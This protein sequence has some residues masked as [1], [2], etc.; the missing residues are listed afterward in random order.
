MR[1]R[2]SVAYW[3]SIHWTTAD[4]LGTTQNS[5]F[6]GEYK[7]GMATELPL[8]RR[9]QLAALAHIRHTH[10]RYDKLLRETTWA[11]ARKAVEQACLDVI[12]KWRGDEETG[13]DQLDEILRE[14]IEIS[15]DEGGSD[16]DSSDAE[17]APTTGLSRGKSAGPGTGP[18][19]PTLVR[20]PVPDASV[21]AA[22]TPCQLKRQTRKERKKARIE[23]KKA[24][25]RYRRYAALAD[26]PSNGSDGPGQAQNAPNAANAAVD[27]A[28]PDS[29]PPSKEQ[30]QTPLQAQRLEQEEYRRHFPSGVVVYPDSGFAEPRNNSGPM[31]ARHVDAPAR[32]QSPLFV[33]VRDGNAPKV[34]LAPPHANGQMPLSPVR[35][36]LEDML[37][38]SIEP[39][40]P[41]GYRSPSNLGPVIPQAPND[42]SR[43]GNHAAMREVGGFA[44]HP[45]SPGNV[46]H[47]E[48][49]VSQP[50]R[51]LTQYA[52]QPQPFSDA[53]F[54][55]VVRVNRDGERGGRP[56]EY[57]SG[58]P[59]ASHTVAPSAY[60]ERPRSPVVY[61]DDAAYPTRE[62]SGRT[63]ANPIVVGDS[64][65][66]QR[67]MERVFETRGPPAPD[68]ARPV[69][70]TDYQR[71]AVAAQ[72]TH[73]DP[74]GAR[75]IY[76]DDR[77]PRS[78]QFD[79]RGQG[80]VSYHRMLPQAERQFIPSPV[81]PA[82]RTLDAPYDHQVRYEDPYRG[83]QANRG[84]VEVSSNS[85][86][87]PQ[88]VPREV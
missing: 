27:T 70:E 61:T 13:R 74:G 20:G 32:G 33:R 87:Q 58:R 52:T 69:R 81:G 10:T 80:H 59:A 25:Q 8:A 29:R 57:V 62:C 23:K 63:R 46:A 75:V 2:R 45:A 15:D 26:G 31:P 47:A 9:V 1:F 44:T 67:T 73:R 4:A 86:R 51:I 40:S 72:E 71:E 36:R 65:R 85:T 12:V 60:M 83:S 43:V 79:N 5:K 38:P 14:V 55:R 88:P 30:R 11:N 76:L 53:G 56:V 42:H 77:D 6:N 41:N 84:P 68:Y 35:H 54:I 37:L 16:D 17:A 50:R 21:A 28:R 49:L 82:S 64:P 7:V 39:R 3:S 24:V 66:A 48:N 19:D 22:L 78:R 18:T 34:G